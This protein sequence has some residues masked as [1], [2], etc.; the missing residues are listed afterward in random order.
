MHAKAVYTTS[1]AVSSE[2]IGG[3]TLPHHHLSHNS[4]RHQGKIDAQATEIA[5]VRS[6]LDKALEEYKNLNICSTWTGK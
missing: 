4:H 1:A 6:E 2:E 5:A 3:D